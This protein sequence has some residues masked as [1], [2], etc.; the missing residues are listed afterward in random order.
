[1][2]TAT[3]SVYDPK[4]ERDGLRLLITRYWPRGIR[5]TAFDRWERRVA[6]SAALVKAF[7]HEGLGWPEYRRRYLAEMDSDDA[8]A[9]LR[10]I[11]A[12]AGRGTVTI[13]CICRDER[14]CHRGILKDLLG[15][16]R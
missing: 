13:I 1:M 10:D 12:A 6:P 3:K 8:R 2:P 9:G 15:A 16:E 14:R 7:K 4:E 5:K 11:A